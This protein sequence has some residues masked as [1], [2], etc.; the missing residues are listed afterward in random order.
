MSLQKQF[1]VRERVR[2][3]LRLDAFNVFNHTIFTGYNYTLNFAAYPSSGGLITGSPAVASNALGRNANGTPNLTGFGSPT[4]TNPG[5]FGY[6]RVL[7]TV[8]RV[9]F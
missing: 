5:A 6:A 7:Q 2:F 4:Q 9:T 8:L 3:Q 1:A